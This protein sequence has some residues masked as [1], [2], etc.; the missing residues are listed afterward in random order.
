MKTLFPS[1]AA[2]ENKLDANNK[3]QTPHYIDLSKI[4]KTRFSHTTQ[5]KKD[6]Y[7]YICHH[8]RNAAL[9]KFYQP[10]QK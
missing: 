3:P 9:Q 2:P 8:V 5:R 7:K 1:Y 4:N 10:H 6:H